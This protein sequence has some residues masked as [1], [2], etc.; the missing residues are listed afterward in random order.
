MDENRWEGLFFFL[1][2]SQG[3]REITS[4]RMREDSPISISLMGGQ[5]SHHDSQ[6]GPQ[7]PWHPME[8]VNTTRVLQFKSGFE[9]RLENRVNSQTWINRVDKES[10]YPYLGPGGEVAE[11]LG[12]LC[13]WSR[14]LPPMLS[15]GPEKQPYRKELIP[16]RGDSPSQEAS[17]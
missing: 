11:G 17:C 2:S 3:R 16:Q 10:T 6:D 14:L 9:D 5:R 12:I 1:L 7:Y 13:H 8:V 4:E 15:P